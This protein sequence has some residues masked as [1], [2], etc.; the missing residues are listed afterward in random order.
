MHRRPKSGT[1]YGPARITRRRLGGNVKKETATATAVGG[2][3]P[4]QTGK[5]DVFRIRERTRR[6]RLWKVFGTFGV[7]DGYLWYRYLTD[8][9]LRLP[10][11]GPEW[12]IWAP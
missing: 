12:V 4:V 9:P 3:K 11:L 10:A 7:V 8:N 1:T 6:K 2:S 5:A